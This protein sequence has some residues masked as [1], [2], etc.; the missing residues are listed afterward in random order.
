M[1]VTGL[2]IVPPPSASDQPK[3]TPELLASVLAR[4]SRS[5]DG[6]ANILAKV[7][8]ANPDASI[9]RILKFVDY[10]HASIGGLTGGLAIALDNVSM[11]LAYKIFE[12]A[13]MADGQESS[14]RYITMAPTS[15]PAPA[16]LG[17]PDDLA[18]RWQDV[19]AR[20][21]AAYN[22]EYAR[23]DALALAK[24]ELVRIPAG[25]KEA[26]VTRL[27]KNYALDR[28]RYF[29]PFAT[30]TNLALVQSS[31]MWAQLVKQLDSLPHPEARAAAKLL[32]DELMKQS[33]RLMR[34]SNADAACQA[35]AAAELEASC[36]LGLEQLSTDGLAD[37]TWVHVDRATPPFLPESQSI[38]E[39]LRH[40]A[41]RYGQQ[42]SATRRMRVTFAF[43]NIAIAELRDLNRHRTGNRYTPLIQAGFY[44][45]PEIDRAAHAQLLD[46]QAELT[47]ELMR[48]GSAAYVHGML[49]GAQTPFEH[50]THADKFIYEAELRTGMGAHFRYAEHLSAAL[51]EFFKQVPEA[52]QWV[53]EGTAEP[54]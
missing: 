12:L 32:R 7:D 8:L 15:L 33:P 14:T 38:A 3:V 51:R 19:M 42:G 25:A 26:V 48:R 34:H 1:K 31:R 43:N 6:L 21:F 41:N 49:L 45:P 2:A 35:Q 30:R 36:A 39:A 23:L 9:D 5:N 52:K 40:R 10:G 11:W 13:Q 22:T 24:P 47:R 28:A 18:A 53:V 46:D 44:L 37:E 16:E 29:I 17:I 50:G 54:E 4:Y 20:A 27:R